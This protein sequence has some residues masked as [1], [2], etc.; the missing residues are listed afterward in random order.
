VFTTPYVVIEG[1]Y[2]VPADSSL[3]SAN[4]VDRDGVRIAVREGSAYDL[5]LTRSLGQAEVVRGDEATDVY[6]ASGLEVCAG[7]RQ[8]MTEYAEQSGGRVLEPPFMEINQAVGLPRALGSDAVSA[9]TE[10][11]EH[12]K[13]SGFVEAALARSGVDA[14]V[15]PPARGG[16]A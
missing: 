9:V 8:P 16:R 7:I 12:L 2:V 10:H 14:T 6:E 11:I 3:D 5:F 1:V 4:D 15:A 13:A